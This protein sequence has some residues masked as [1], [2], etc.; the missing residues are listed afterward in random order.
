MGEQVKNLR[1]VCN[2]LWNAGKDYLQ[3]NGELGITWG[4]WYSLETQARMLSERVDLHEYQIQCDD[5]STL[6]QAR[7]NTKIPIISFVASSFTPEENWGNTVDSNGRFI[8]TRR[9]N[10]VFPPKEK[11]AYTGCK[12]I[13]HEGSHTVMLL[14][15]PAAISYFIA[16]NGQPYTD[17]PFISCYEDDSLV[18]SVHKHVRRKYMTSWVAVSVDTD[19]LETFGVKQDQAF[20][21]KVEEKVTSF[22]ALLTAKV[23]FKTG[24]GN[25]PNFVLNEVKFKRYKYYVCPVAPGV[26]IATT[27]FWVDSSPLIQELFY[28]PSL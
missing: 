8:T 1:Y 3:L 25:V 6:Q 27:A 10:A 17:I 7:R 28:L 20:W 16:L 5:S 12:K 15:D 26:T 23:G 22:V 9:E 18:D 13:R 11:K 4:N 2:R 14:S 24:K 21:L 19:M